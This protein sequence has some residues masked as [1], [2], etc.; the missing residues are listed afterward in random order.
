M[1]AKYFFL[2]A[3]LCTIAILPACET[4]KEEQFWQRVSTSEAIYLQGPKAQQMLHRD[5]GRCV[6]EL[7][8][9]ERL[10]VLKNTIPVDESGRVLDPDELAMRDWDTPERDGYLL[11]EHRNYHDFESCMWAKGW[12]RVEHVPYDI[13]EKSR[14]D[15]LKAHKD[16]KYQSRVGKR[17]RSMHGYTSDPDFKELND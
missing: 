3:C 9:L 7:K 13:A 6:V 8:E 2:T 15:Y 10:G 1:S 12:E 11:A 5:I 16:Y 14:G 17:H 4:R